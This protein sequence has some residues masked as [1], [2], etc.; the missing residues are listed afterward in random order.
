MR[1]EFSVP[2]DVK[3][4]VIRKKCDESHKLYEQ[5]DV[6]KDEKRCCKE[7]FGDEVSW[8]CVE[9]QDRLI[10]DDCGV[11]SGGWIRGWLNIAITIYNKNKCKKAVYH[12]L[13]LN[14][15]K[16]LGNTTKTK[17]MLC[18]IFFPSGKI[19]LRHCKKPIDRSL[20]VWIQVIVPSC[21]KTF[22]WIINDWGH[23]YLK[24]WI[25]F[26]TKGFALIRTAWTL[27]NTQ[28]ETSLWQSDERPK[29]GFRGENIFS[30]NNL[31]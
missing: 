16:V 2:V 14:R 21:L 8:Y 25:M 23:V 27:V 13:H 30:D 10:I 11:G 29:C 7:N 5:N 17:L 31:V 3:W 6:E 9:Y 4:Y 22:L 20:I 15:K 28:Q 24:F 19:Y 12:Q 1:T 18:W 26:E